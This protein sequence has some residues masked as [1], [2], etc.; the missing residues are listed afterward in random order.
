M[1]LACCYV[2]FIGITK[3]LVLISK[4]FGSLSQSDLSQE[5][6]GVVVGQPRSHWLREMGGKTLLSAGIFLHRSLHK[7][8]GLVLRATQ[9]LHRSVSRAVGFLAVAILSI[10]R[11]DGLNTKAL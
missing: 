1:K 8:M 10:R 5:A 7:Q 9:V 3:P 2:E 6:K 4:V 11:E